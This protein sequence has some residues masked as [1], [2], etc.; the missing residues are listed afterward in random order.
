MSVPTTTAAGSLWPADRPDVHYPPPTTERHFDVL[1]LGSGIT[2][3]TT[4]L[5]LRRS[6]ARVAG[7][8]ADRIGLE[9]VVLMFDEH[10]SDLGSA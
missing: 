3:L 2:G 7:V 5:L 9:Q 10:S 6:G 1:V 8:W 4:A